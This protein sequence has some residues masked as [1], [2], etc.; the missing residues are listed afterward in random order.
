MTEEDLRA[1]VG[2]FIGVSKRKGLKENVDK[3]MLLQGEEGSACEAIKYRWSPRLW[4][5]VE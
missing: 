5:N 4:E 1:M 3:V 2:S